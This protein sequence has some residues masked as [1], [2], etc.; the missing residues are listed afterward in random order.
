MY[1]KIKP[2]SGTIE[3]TTHLLTTMRHIRRPVSDE[4][5]DELTTFK[6]EKKEM[7]LSFQGTQNNRLDLLSRYLEKLKSQNSSI[8]ITNQEIK[9]FLENMSHQ[10]VTKVLVDANQDQ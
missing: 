8:F 2:K 10:L 4:S 7:L 6:M 9:N 3:N 1:T 5:Y